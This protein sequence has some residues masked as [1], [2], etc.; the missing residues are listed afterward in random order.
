MKPILSILLINIIFVALCQIGEPIKSSESLLSEKEMNDFRESLNKIKKIKKYLRKLEVDT[1]E[2]GEES[3]ESE[4]SESSGEEPPVPP[5]N[6]TVIPSDVP[7]QDVSQNRDA[8]VHIKKLNNFA[9]TTPPAPKNPLKPVVFVFNLFIEFINTPTY[10]TVRFT[11]VIY[12]SRL[13][14]LQDG[15]QNIETTVAVCTRNDSFIST[16]T[17]YDCEAEATQASAN[18]EKIETVKDF[19]VTTDENNTPTSVQ[20]KD[21]DFSPTAKEALEDLTKPQSSAIYL[22]DIKDATVTGPTNNI[23]YIKGSLN[24]V[25]KENL[26]KLGQS[27][28]FNFHNGTIDGDAVSTNCIVDNEDTNDFILKCDKPSGFYG[29]LFLYQGSGA[30]TEEIEVFVN[31]KPDNDIVSFPR[32]K[33]GESVVYRKNSSGLS[34]GVIAGIVIACAAVLIIITVLALYL[35][36]PKTP[37][38]NNSTIVGLKSVENYQE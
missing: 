3:E 28:K 7:P 37:V 18:P 5:E 15:N 29:D 11:L 32:P 12:R 6:Q 14:E 35:K 34:G 16:N 23:F 8:A 25:E 33:S 2:S 21:L 22:A 4:E 24:G 20:A 13:R 31:T 30:L 19:Q 9:S 17:K 36:S 27:I 26:P 38:N 10:K 1:S